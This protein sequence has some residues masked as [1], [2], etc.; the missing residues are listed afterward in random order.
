MLIK[1]VVFIVMRK[2]QKQRTEFQL[3]E[4][5]YFITLM[6]FFI[7]SL[8]LYITHTYRDYDY[9]ELDKTVVYD[10]YI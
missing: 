6:L 4:N 8:I 3:S 10:L 1:T 7:C 5:V 2:Y 9:Q